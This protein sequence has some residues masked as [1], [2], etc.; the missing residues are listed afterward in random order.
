MA[1]A[2]ARPSMGKAPEPAAMAPRLLRVAL[3]ALAAAPVFAQQPP[4]AAGELDFNRLRQLIEQSRQAKEPTPEQQRAAILQK[5]KIDRSPAGILEARLADARAEDADTGPLPDDAEDAQRLAAFQQR[6]ETFRRD[7]LLGR[8]ERAAAFLDS[9]PD[10]LAGNAYKIVL[11][12]LASPIQVKPSP[13]LQA[14]GAKPHTE[15]AFLP[16]ME[17]LGLAAA[18]PQPPQGEILKQLT[19]LLSRETP[20]PAAFFEKLEEGVRHFGGEDL[21]ARS[22][23]AELLLETG[24]AAEAGPFLPD[25]AKARTEREYAALN[26]IARHRAALAEADPE[27]AGDDA[28]PLAWEL[29]T[30]FLTDEDAPAPARAEALFRALSLIPELDDERGRE[31]L[32]DTFADPEGAGLELLTTLGRLTAQNRENP[33]ASVRHEYLRLQH[34]AVE[35]VLAS[36]AESADWA[37]IFTLYARQWTH[38][39]AFT[40][41]RDQSESRRMTPQFDPF[42]NVF[43]TQRSAPTSTP[44]QGGKGPVSSA[45]MLDCRPDEPWLAVIG[46]TTRDECLT[47]AARLLLKV[48]EEDN[49]L[50][51]VR[52]LADARPGEAAELVR[53]VIE[54]WA[55][56]HNPNTEQQYRSSYMYFYG[57]NQ[58]AGSIPLT[59]SQQE[60][61]LEELAELVEGVRSLELDESFHREFADAFIACHS[62]AEVW[63]VEAIQAVFGDTGAL[64]AA[65]LESLVGRMRMN[66][67]GLWP[68]PRLQQAYQTKRDDKELQR[69]IL[70][71]YGAAKNLL[72]RALDRGAGDSWRLAYQLAALRFEESN[73]RSSIAPDSTHSATKRAALDEL[74]AA[75]EAYAATL[76][77]AS[78]EEESTA[79]YETWFFAALGSPTLGALEGHHLPTP[80]EYPRIR[81]ALRTLPGEAAERHVG[82][83]ANTLNTRLPNVAP[84]L[85][86]RYLEAATTVCPDRRELRDAAE[87][88][89]YYRDLVAEIELDAR[90]DGPDLVS[91]GMPFG[92][93]VDLRHTRA[94][95]RESGGFQRYLQNQKNQ[96]YAVNYGRPPEDYRDKFEKAARAALE[97][98]FDVLSVTF[99][100]EDVASRADPEFGW[101]ITPYAY[102]LL[103][104]RGPQVDRI[105]PLEIDLDFTDT[106]G[107][108]IIPITSPEIPIDASGE[109][110][111]RPFRE[112]RLVQTLDERSLEEKGGLF[113]EI[114]A[115]GHGLVPPLETLFDPAVPGFEVG[116]VEDNSVLITELDATSDDLAPLSE[117][118]W[119]VEYR[120][121]GGTLPATF[122]F[123]D[124]AV[125][126]AAEDGLLRQRYVD[127]DLVPAKAEAP[128]DADRAPVSAWLIAAI[129]LA[130]GLVAGAVVHFLRR[131]AKPEPTAEPAPL[132]SRL[133]PV[134]LLGFLRR[135]RVA[136]EHRPALDREITELESRYFGPGP[137]DESDA[138]LEGV[139]DRW[140]QVAR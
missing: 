57:Y 40:Q 47:A 62:K 103:E 104:P 85:K 101:R 122:E 109:P 51:L 66:L 68:D 86:L 44:P 5:L 105:P 28:I 91:P 112:L 23:A 119:R 120:P 11:T 136:D 59:R 73:Y 81:D 7:V 25:L 55:E 115:S 42:G 52:R 106:S 123:P 117:R 4:Q 69:Q 72:E 71:G 126:T 56:N 95:E 76:P 46:P 89:A 13:D 130:A 50:P 131:R 134:T 12:K 127:V 79:V 16:P 116:A 26:L 114:R 129:V 34:A 67:A 39:A 30:S 60:R 3:L 27:A 82:K 139:A 18:A 125:E 54:V 65:T 93:H 43:Y 80:A 97:E 100:S 99:H 83:F 61:N 19:G 121:V 41:E 92:L 88:L 22:R 48:K 58:R 9:Q 10:S 90:I 49:A 24:F 63:R 118:E 124:P 8:W 75:A 135:L 140:R 6:A 29:S 33:E 74:A 133:T 98:H 137:T 113:L 110:E 111:P 102:F 37:D 128:L 31:W 32:R 138:A 45:D 132:P 35:A 94:I 107:Y 17:W 78:R 84:E 2:P 14:R 70:E 64:D 21:E 15:P 108:V 38:E 77:R 96:A 1:R 36:G 87:V 53:E 20:P